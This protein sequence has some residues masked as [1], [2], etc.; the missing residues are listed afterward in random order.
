MNAAEEGKAMLDRIDEDPDMHRLFEDFTQTLSEAA[1]GFTVSAEVEEK[2]R[3]IF[4][5]GAFAMLMTLSVKAMRE[6]RESDAH[7][8]VWQWL[9]QVRRAAE[10]VS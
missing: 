2:L 10:A 9:A 7:R 1:G 5:S 8:V 6:D 4:F 3:L